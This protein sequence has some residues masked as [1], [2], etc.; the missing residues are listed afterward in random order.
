MTTR[1]AL[2]YLRTLLPND[3]QAIAAL[4]VLEMLA[5]TADELAELHVEETAGSDA[6]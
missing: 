4:G 2:A 6:K 3:P 5:D 1:E